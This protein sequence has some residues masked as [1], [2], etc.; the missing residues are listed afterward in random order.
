MILQALRVFILFFLIGILTLCTYTP[1]EEFFNEIEQFDEQSLSISL[2]SYNESDTIYLE[3]PAEFKYNVES[4]GEI[5]EVIIL[6][7]NSKIATG[8]NSGVFAVVPHTGIYHLEIRFI[9]ST[10]TGSLADKVGA[11]N[12]QVWKTWIIK[13]YVETIPEKPVVSTTM[14]NG[15]SVLRWTPYNKTKFEHYAIQVDGE[16]K[17]YIMN[18]ETTTWVDST[19]LGYHNRKYT[20]YTTNLI[21]T[22][23]SSV[24][25][26]GDENLIIS[27]T[28]NPADSLVELEVSKPIY[29]GPF[30]SYSIYEN[31][32]L[33]GQIENVDN[34][35]FSFKSRQVGINYTSNVSVWLNAKLK[36]G[37]GGSRTV[38]N[39]SVVLQNLPRDIEEF[40]FNNELQT[41]I[42]YWSHLSE[43][44]FFKL[45]PNNLEMT[46]SIEVNNGPGYHVSYDGQNIYYSDASQLVE[47]NL[48]T[49]NE[50]RLDAITTEYG[51]GPSNIMSSQNRIVCYDW[52]GP[53][54][55]I[56]FY[57]RIFNL[58]T[59][60]EIAFMSK[61][62]EQVNYTISDDGNYVKNQD[63]DI[64]KIID[65]NLLLIG[66]LNY[67]GRWLGFRQDA[68]EEM[69][70]IDNY[71]DP[72]IRIYDVNS[73]EEKRSVRPSVSDSKFI[74]YDVAS[75]S[76][77]FMNYGLK[78]L[79]RIDIDNGTEE[80]FN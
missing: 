5:L 38:L 69:L 9:S 54:D 29:F 36:Q 63:N 25:L 18:P 59:N 16:E 75:K 80:Q 73:L 41:I 71:Y 19:Y 76:L 7:N 1:E 31:G 40:A 39:T 49:Y 22:S 42:G 64:Y 13:A 15:Y 11:E 12:I 20:V 27:S 51:S 60:K 77:I 58:T 46:D 56:T 72:A 4:D 65:D 68:S 32:Q 55:R 52:F 43:G 66:R 53:G 79:Y 67:T 70:T 3:G 47:M 28:F 24:E 17:K 44:K 23:R 21:G 50:S 8:K 57:S 37:I 6:L 14:E 74:T 48:I 33:I 78:K 2:D 35:T 62:N 61:D 26:T 30:K 34:T 10:G 45:N